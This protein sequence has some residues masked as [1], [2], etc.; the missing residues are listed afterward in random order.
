MSHNSVHLSFILKMQQL[1]EG[2]ILSGMS[3]LCI[4]KQKPPCCV[5]SPKTKHSV[6]NADFTGAL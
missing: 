5:I 2:I 3:A 6:C 1:E 4:G